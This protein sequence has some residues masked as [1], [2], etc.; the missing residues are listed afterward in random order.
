MLKLM[1]NTVTT[2]KR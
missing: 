2:V 1:V